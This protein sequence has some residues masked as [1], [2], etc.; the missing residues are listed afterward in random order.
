MDWHEET[1]DR[2][3][4]LVITSSCIRGDKKTRFEIRGS[5]YDLGV[6]AIDSASADPNA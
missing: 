1:D 6:I 2:G 4:E 5:Q 3:N